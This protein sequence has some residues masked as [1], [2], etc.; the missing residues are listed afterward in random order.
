MA[1]PAATVNRLRASD[2]ST[3]LGGRMADEILER[4]LPVVGYEGLYSVSDQG[5]VRSEPRSCLGCGGTQRRVFGKVLR[6]TVLPNGYIQADL[7]KDNIPAHH[8]VHRLVLIAF[9]GQPNIGEE[10]CHNDGCRSNNALTNLRWDTRSGN[11]ADK[12]AHGTAPRGTNH[13]FVKLTAAQILAI[14]NDT[15][16]LSTIANDYGVCFGHIGQI[17]RRTAWTWLRD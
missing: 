7:R 16:S 3:C 12:A 11:H 10:A 13:P 5:R 9:S 2:Q 4:W 1:R 6:P 8:Y 15:R 14:R 17:K